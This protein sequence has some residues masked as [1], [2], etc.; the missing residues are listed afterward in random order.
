VVADDITL[1]VP[2][3][4]CLGVLGPNGAGKT[5]LLSLISGLLKP[6]AGDITLDGRVITKTSPALRCHLGIGRAFQVPRPFSHM[7][8]L[9]NILVAVAF[10]QGVSE[11]KAQPL[12]QHVL[13]TT[14]L[15]HIA[16]QQSG[17][18]PLLDRK[19]LE[20][21]R[22]LATN[23]SVILLDEIAGGLTDSE[24]LELVQT[25]NLIKAQGITII[26]I[27]HVVHALLSV[28]ER[29][30]VVNFGK[31]IADGDPT[32]VMDSPIVKQVYL[33]ME[34]A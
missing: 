7:S 14:G 32:T 5:S 3:G 31:I 23:P 21:A 28:A 6:D 26:W 24:W 25:I 27:E 8:I 15:A 22:A 1:D 17:A 2:K 19:R 4:Q 30:I 33:G 11:K 29:L 18:L 34:A 9:E 20:F 13:E 12:A 16:N 10:G